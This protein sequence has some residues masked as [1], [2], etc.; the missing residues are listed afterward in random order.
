MTIV[1][2]I[3]IVLLYMISSY[4]VK[5]MMILTLKGFTFV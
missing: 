4:K 2:T 5:I 1:I 3:I